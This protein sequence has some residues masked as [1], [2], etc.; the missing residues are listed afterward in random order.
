[1]VVDEHGDARTLACEP[2]ESGM[3]GVSGSALPYQH[4]EEAQL[5]LKEEPMLLWKT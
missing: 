1:M 4:W 2:C 3:R 5:L